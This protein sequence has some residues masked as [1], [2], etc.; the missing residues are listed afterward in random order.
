MTLG[1]GGGDTFALPG[2][3]NF[4]GN[5]ASSVG[6]AITTEGGVVDFGTG[7]ADGGG[8]VTLTA[9]STVATTAG[10]ID[11]GANIIFRGTVAGGFDLGLTAGTGGAINF[12]GIDA[13]G[14][15]TLNNL[16]LSSAGSSSIAGNLAVNDLITTANVGPVVMT[17]ATN[18]FDAEVASSTPDPPIG[19][20]APG[21][22]F[23]F[24]D[25]L[26]F[27][28]NTA[29]VLDVATLP[30][31]GDL[32]DFGSGGVTVTTPQPLQH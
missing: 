18:T 10:G 5:A 28:T 24:N 12:D 2:G 15:I 1:D 19:G 14:A 3:L 21:S 4:A 31:S 8:G 9:N 30:S 22:V 6:A 25:G 26:L 20:G 27:S 16:T 32:I 13:A 29:S 17:G 23:T 7:T 11:A